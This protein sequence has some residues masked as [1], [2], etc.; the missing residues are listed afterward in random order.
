ML[1]AYLPT[2]ESLAPHVGL[3]LSQVGSYRF[4]DPEGEVGIETHILTSTADVV[5]QIPLTYRSQ[6]LEGEESWLLGTM[7]HSV[8]GKRWIY[9]ACGDSVY[10][11][12]LMR[13]MVTGGRE[14]PEMV[15][16]PDGPIER[17]ASVNVQG[18]G[19]RDS[20]V[21]PVAEIV[22]ETDGTETHIDCGDLVVVVRHVLAGDLP[23]P[24][25]HSLTGTWATSHGPVA[26]ASMT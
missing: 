18:S 2:V 25:T 9:N 19:A 26:L 23:Q 22:P 5:L 3:N 7:E 21:P 4:D 1:G 16:T 15:E 20:A 17:S 11:R 14:V 10:V 12:E 8:L 13:A 24:G 6:P